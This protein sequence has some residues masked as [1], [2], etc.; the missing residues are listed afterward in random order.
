MPVS[1]LLLALCGLVLVGMPFFSIFFSE[2]IILWSA[3]QRAVVDPI[4]I[5]AV[6]L[7]LISVTFIFAGLVVHL[8][9]IV[10]GKSPLSRGKVHENPQQLAPLGVLLLLLVIG[11]FT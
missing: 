10:L 1:G 11:G 9:R 2:F 6:C 8:G 4:M 7:F 3:F 5:P